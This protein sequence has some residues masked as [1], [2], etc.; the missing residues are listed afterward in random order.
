MELLSKFRNYLLKNYKHLNAGRS[1]LFV[2]ISACVGFILAV[3]G[4]GLLLEGR[5]TTGRICVGIGTL[6]ALANVIQIIFK[7]I[8]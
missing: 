4:A 3:V 1:P 8:I 2:V 5:N 7:K 6:S